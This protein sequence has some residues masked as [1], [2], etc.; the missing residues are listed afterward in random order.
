M[1]GRSPPWWKPCP[2]PPEPVRWRRPR[3]AVVGAGRRRGAVGG[4]RSGGD[5][6]VGPPTLPQGRRGAVRGPGTASGRATPRPG[7]DVPLMIAGGTPHEAHWGDAVSLGACAPLRAAARR[8][9]RRGAVGRARGVMGVTRTVA[10]AVGRKRRDTDDHDGGRRGGTGL[11]AAVPEKALNAGGGEQVEEGGGVGVLGCV[12]D[13][14]AYLVEQVGFHLVAGVGAAQAA[15]RAAEQRAQLVLPREPDRLLQIDVVQRPFGRA[16][17]ADHPPFGQVVDLDCHVAQHEDVLVEVTVRDGEPV[18]GA[19]LP[20]EACF[21][22]L[23]R[24]V[25]TKHYRLSFRVLR[26]DALSVWFPSTQERLWGFCPR[27]SLS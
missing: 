8:R 25:Y 9:L 16:V 4:P 14:R 15:N 3:T 11:P 10:G 7:C 5:A 21:F 22:E 24:H 1:P 6:S 18:A 17:E 13:E 23:P 19:G 2:T 12:G 26:S 20:G 27:R